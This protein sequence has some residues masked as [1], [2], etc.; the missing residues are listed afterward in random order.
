MCVLNSSSHVFVPLQLNKPQDKA[1]AITETQPL[2]NTETYYYETNSGEPVTVR[3]IFLTL[4][5]NAE[6]CQSHSM[7]IPHSVAS[8]FFYYGVG[9]NDFSHPEWQAIQI[10]YLINYTM[11]R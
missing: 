5:C 10:L 2:S 9:M 3:S 8:H 1:T 11:C 4:M 6:I 7:T